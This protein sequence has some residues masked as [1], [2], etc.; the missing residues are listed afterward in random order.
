MVD[1]LGHGPAAAQAAERATLAIAQAS[2]EDLGAVMRHCD[3]ALRGTRGAAVTLLRIGRDGKAEHCGI[4][5]IALAFF[6][7]RASAATPGPGSWA[8]GRAR[9]AST[10]SR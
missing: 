6:G 10:S 3:A 1:G 2:W 7:Q 5:N 4:G 9:S 8:R